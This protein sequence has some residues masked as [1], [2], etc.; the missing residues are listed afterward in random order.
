MRTDET[1][2]RERLMKMTAPQLRELAKREDI[3]IT[4]LTE[5]RKEQLVDLILEELRSRA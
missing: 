5:R 2:E 4:Y 3:H 1:T